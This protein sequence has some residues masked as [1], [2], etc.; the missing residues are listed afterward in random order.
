MA[1][2]VE[3][4]QLFASKNGGDFTY[5]GQFPGTAL[6]PAGVADGATYSF[7]I[8][9]TDAV[10]NAEVIIPS[11][12]SFENTMTDIKVVPADQ[13]SLPTDG[14]IYTMDGR[15][16]G[17]SFEGLPAGAYLVGGKKVYVK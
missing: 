16:V 17:T 13:Q 2:G 7:Y 5:A 12:L 8:L 3:S 14:K 10:G 9:A 4:Y 11:A 6:Y 1:S 15:Y